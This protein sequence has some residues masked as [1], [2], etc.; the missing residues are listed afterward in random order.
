[1]KVD[2]ATACRGLVLLPDVVEP[3]N[4]DYI[5]DYVRAA[6]RTPKLAQGLA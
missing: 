4:V 2:K 5:R 1:M 3:H 6:V